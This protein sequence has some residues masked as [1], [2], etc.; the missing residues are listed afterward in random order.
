MLSGST[1]SKSQKMRAS[2]YLTEGYLMFGKPVNGAPVTAVFSADTDGGDA[3]LLLMPPARSERK[4]M[5]GYI[6]SPN[7]NE[8]FLQAIFIFT[9]GTA[10]SLLEQIHSGTAKRTPD[11]GAVMLGRWGQVVTNLMAGF[12]SRLVLDLLTPGPRPGFFEA[13]LD[14][15]KLGNFDLIYDERAFEQLLAGQV[16]NRKDGTWWDTWTSFISRSH[17]GRP[18]PEPEEQILS[19]QID[20]TLDSALSLH[21]TTRMRVRISERSQNVIALDLTGQMRAT[22]AKIDG[23]TG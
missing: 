15:K 12:E 8:H 23:R 16:T 10:K 6:G 7:L 13:V 21:C 14:G 11:I 3:E 4:S 9:D 17:K 20:A 19:Y 2:V 18:Q 1:I 22:A 5:A